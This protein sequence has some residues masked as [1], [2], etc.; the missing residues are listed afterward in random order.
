MGFS[1]VSYFLHLI[2]IMKTFKKGIVIS[3]VAAVTF[4]SCNGPRKD[5]YQSMTKID[6]HAHIRTEDPAIMEFAKEQGFKF[7]TINTGSES[8]EH[9]DNQM[10]VAK[11]VKNSYPD[12]ISYITTFPMEN[13]EDPTWAEEVILQL[14]KD[15]DEGAVGVKAWKD[16]GM[17]FRD[18]LGN[19]IFIDDPRFDPVFDFIA[20][21]GKTFIGHIGEPKNCWLPIDSM[22]V[23]ND[24]LY[25]EENPQY[26]MYL[27][28]EDPSYERLVESRDHVLAKHPDLKFVG[29]HLGSLEW[30][31]DELAERLDL[32]PN[33]AVDM[34]ARVCHFQ[35][36]D[37]EKVRE[38]LIRYQDRVLYATDI[39]IS[40]EDDLQERIAWLEN[41]WK[42]DWTY[43]A[44]GESMNSPHVEGTFKGL[45][46]EEDVLRKIYSS[47]AMNWFPG[48]FE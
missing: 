47:N 43:F 23:N 37:R 42:S 28:P 18:S 11:L 5:M 33:F 13:F 40:E 15:F 41:E 2:Q 7:I 27:H 46:L 20:G 1:P 32:Y 9:I 29:A 30:D 4:L 17:T 31:V 36:Q 26:H 45:D 10:R 44:T 6:A 25:F 39:V 16:I 48:L 21:K 34:A 19:F 12:R 38:F 3:I 22:T 35:V 8:Q 24:K 14:Q